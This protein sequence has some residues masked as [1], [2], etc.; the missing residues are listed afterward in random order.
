MSHFISVTV[1]EELQ[2]VISALERIFKARTAPGKEQ[3]DAFEVT[4]ELPVD[5][6]GL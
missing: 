1:D 3:P 2:F 4:Q 5:S 6:Q